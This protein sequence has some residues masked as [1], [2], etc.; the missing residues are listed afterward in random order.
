MSNAN[1]ARY[2]VIISNAFVMEYGR[3]RCM[4]RKPIRLQ[5]TSAAMRK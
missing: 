4:R 1:P 2:V 3:Q 5:T